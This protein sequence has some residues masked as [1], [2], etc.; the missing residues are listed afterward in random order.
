MEKKGFPLI[1]E[2]EKGFERYARFDTLKALGFTFEMKERIPRPNR[3]RTGAAP[4]V[5]RRGGFIIK[6]MA[7]TGIYEK[8]CVWGV[9]GPLR[10]AYNFASEQLG[11]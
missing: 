10:R 11:I 2:E 4:T 5:R 7:K 1:F 9:D 6:F 3:A 8:F